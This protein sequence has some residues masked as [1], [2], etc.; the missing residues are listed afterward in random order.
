MPRE[1]SA[2]YSSADSSSSCLGRC[3]RLFAES[4]RSSGVIHGRE[5]CPLGIAE[6]VADRDLVFSEPHARYQVAQPLAGTVVY[7]IREYGVGGSADWEAGLLGSYLSEF[8]VILLCEP[9]GHQPVQLP[10]EVAV[11]FIIGEDLRPSGCVEL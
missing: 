7:P 11:D 6:R 2:A 4:L 9:G 3:D 1:A 5:D 8:P 10:G